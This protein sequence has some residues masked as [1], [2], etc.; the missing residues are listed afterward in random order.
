MGEQGYETPDQMSVEDEQFIQALNEAD[1]EKIDQ[2]LLSFAEKRW[3]KVAMIVAQAIQE[4]DKEGIL[5]EI[6]DVFFAKR[7]HHY[8]DIGRLELRGDRSRMRYS[9]VRQVG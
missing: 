9:E 3:K 2:W 8:C 4:S 1:I 7:I 6:P 5:L